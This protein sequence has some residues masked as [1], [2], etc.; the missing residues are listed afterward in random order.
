V[1]VVDRGF[2]P[3]EA[4][5]MVVRLR[6]HLRRAEALRTDGQSDAAARE[7][8]AAD[9]ILEEILIRLAPRF[10]RY[11]WA[12]F[13][14]KP[15]AIREDAVREMVYEICRALKNLSDRSGALHFER[16]FNQAVQSRL[17]DAIKKVHREQD[18]DTEGRAA[19]SLE[20]T[21]E[22]AEENGE[23]LADRVPDPKAT[24]VF[25]SVLGA[26]L[27]ARLLEQLPTPR[28]TQICKA[29]LEGDGWDE[30]AAQVGVSEKTARTYFKEVEARLQKLTAR[31]EWKDAV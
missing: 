8:T 20:T 31:P 17:H 15:E 30:I 21:F 5:Q 13:G 11:A 26:E 27:A 16:R 9:S 3:N 25:E 2:K 28:H 12:A 6:T 19:L 29:R 14:S 7:E 10:E 24:Q 23:S 1:E 18:T 4:E 22:S